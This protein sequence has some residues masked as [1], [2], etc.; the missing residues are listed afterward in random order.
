MANEGDLRV[1]WV[2]QAPMKQFNVPVSS[3]QEGAKLLATLAEY[4]AFQYLNRVKGDYVNGGG[5]QVFEDGEW[6][7][8]QCP[9]T[10]EDNP[11]D[12]Y[13]QPELGWCSQLNG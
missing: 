13:P 5:L 1:W 3:V 2:P 10:F 7:D 12:L 9:D 8:W 11:R 4:D 6:V